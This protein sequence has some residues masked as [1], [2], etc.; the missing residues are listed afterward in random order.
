M[1]VVN[2]K[3]SSS[4]A[5]HKLRDQ[6]NRINQSKLELMQSGRKLSERKSNWFRFTSDE[7]RKWRVFFEANSACSEVKPITS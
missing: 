6:E 2:L 4:I 7:M 3:P 5:S 1:F